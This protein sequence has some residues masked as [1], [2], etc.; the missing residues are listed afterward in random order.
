MINYGYFLDCF[1]GIDFVPLENSNEN[2]TIQINLNQFVKLLNILPP[3]IKLIGLREVTPLFLNSLNDS[4]LGNFEKELREI[5]KLCKEKSIRICTIIENCAFGLASEDES[6]LETTKTIIQSHSEFYDLA[7]LD[8]KN[9][10]FI[11]F[12]KL[13]LCDY[14]IFYNRYLDLPSYMRN[15]IGIYDHNNNASMV[16]AY[17][18]RLP[19]IF[20]IHD[21]LGTNENVL[22]KSI[23][24]FANFGL[25]PSSRPLSTAIS[26]EMPMPS[27]VENH[28][29][30]LLL[31]NGVCD[32]TNKSTPKLKLKRGNDGTTSDIPRSNIGKNKSIKKTKS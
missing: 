18:Q 31:L 12:G 14:E 21:E 24:S 26:K 3:E 30:D 15:R 9:L 17:N 10:I 28:D 27:F 6:Y 1:K 29:L 32:L 11:P 8:Y 13:Y 20:K 25:A 2:K 5:G 4:S 22:K 16:V 23:F 7:H 19:W